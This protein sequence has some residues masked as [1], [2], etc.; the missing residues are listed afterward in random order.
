MVSSS[1]TSHCPDGANTQGFSYVY[2]QYGNRQQQN[3]TAGSGPQPQYSF[4]ASTNH[5]TN[6]GYQYDLAGDVLNDGYCSY[7]WDAEQHMSSATCPAN[8][9]AT[10]T[11]IYDA[12]G[13][14]VAKE[15]GGAVTEAD[16]YNTAGQ[17]VSR[18]GPYPAETWLGDDVWVGGAHLAIYAN[19]Q[20]YFPLTDQV[21]TERARFASTG[22][23]VESCVSLPFGDGLQCTGS[24]PDPYHFAK[25]ER[26]AESGDDHAQHRDYNS[27]PGRWL[28]PDPA[29]TKVVSLT[30]PQTWNL[31]V[32]SG[33]N[34]VTDNDPSGLDPQ[35]CTY[36]GP[37]Y[38]G[39][40]GG[41]DSSTQNIAAQPNNHTGYDTQNQ[42]ARAALNNS[43]GASIKQNREYGGLIYEN[44]N[45]KYH[46]TGPVEGTD[47]GVDPHD[48]KAPRGTRVVGDYHTHGDYSVMGPNGNAVRTH[49]PHRDDFNSNHF[50]RP[51]KQ[52]VANDARGKPEYR[53]YLGTPSG[54]FLEYNPSTDH[55]GPLQ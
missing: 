31:Y 17:V 21:G 36:S 1:C 8:S 12:A 47:Q 38:D 37:C 4:S 53:G 18:Y 39:A 26:D 50:S 10:T 27:I 42:A 13:R 34:P 54:R 30:N 49:D 2:D 35:T 3:V 5:V 25:L 16:V 52:G 14:R 45:G 19:G 43:N 11:Y 15:V 40:S 24:D 6:N 22:G 33:N 28:S 32:Y 55:E 44:K 23:I 41:K 29:G 51:D 48:A 20:T 9:T 7:T 46:F